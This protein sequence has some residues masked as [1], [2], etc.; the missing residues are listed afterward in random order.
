MLIQKIEYKEVTKWLINYKVVDSILIID[1]K[2]L[3][4]HLNCFYNLTHL[5]Y[6]IVDSILNSP[7]MCFDF[8]KSL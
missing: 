8:N 1:I 2:T 7:K 4:T 5:N 6:K 3:L